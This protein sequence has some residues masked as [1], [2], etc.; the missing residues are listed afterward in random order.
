MYSRLEDDW[1]NSSRN[2]NLWGGVEDRRGQQLNENI[3]VI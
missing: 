1:I 2:P 3:I